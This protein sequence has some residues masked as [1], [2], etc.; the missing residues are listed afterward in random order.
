MSEVIGTIT[1]SEDFDDRRSGE[2]A[3]NYDVTRVKAGTYPV[4]TGWNGGRRVLIADMDACMIESYYVNRVFQATSTD[5]K[6]YED[7]E[8]PTTWMWR[9]GDYDYTSAPPTDIFGD[10]RLVLDEGWIVTADYR[11]NYSGGGA[12]IFY[13]IEKEEVKEEAA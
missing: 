3:C 10:M 7:G 8:R 1:L 9:W 4:R 11:G 2:T 5:H 13:A 6:H 12:M